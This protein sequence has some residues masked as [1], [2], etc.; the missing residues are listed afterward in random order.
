MTIEVKGTTVYILGKPYQIKCSESDVI[1]LQE[2]ADF[3]AEKMQEIRKVAHVLSIDR[4][5]LMAALNMSHQLLTLQHEKK[6]ISDNLNERLSTL[7]DN[8][9]K[10]LYP[11]HQMELSSSE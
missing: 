1:S 9:D 5:A 7:Q 10:V 3:L 8:L 2:A 6:C 4:V 11:S